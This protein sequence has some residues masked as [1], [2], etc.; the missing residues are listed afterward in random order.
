MKSI[1]LPGL[2]LLLSLTSTTLA[3]ENQEQSIE[4]FVSEIDK[5]MPQLLHDFTVPGAAIAI[6]ENGA[7]VL[8]KGYG[9]SD[10]ENEVKVN[11]KTGFNIGSISK[12]VAAWGVMKLV[13]EGK[14]DLDAPAEKYLTRWHLPE[15]EFDSDGVT[16]RRLL[17]HTAGLSLHSVS[18]GPPYDKLPTLEDWLIGKNNGLGRVEI[19]L[20]PG[21]RYKYSGGG[22]GVLQLIIEE[23]TG[24]SFEDYM[25]SEVLDPLGMRNSSYKI[26]DKIMAASASPYDNYGEAT[27]FELF[28][29]QAGAGLHTTLED[30]TRF[31]IANLYRHKDNNK[32]NSVLPTDIIQQMMEP[33]LATQGR[34]RRGLGYL[35][36]HMG[37]SWVFSGHGGSNT[38]WQANFTVDPASNDG[39]VGFTNGGAGYAICNMLSCEWTTWKTGES[40]GNW[41]QAKPSIANK[42]KQIIDSKGIDDL[43]A[44]YTELKENQFE[45]YDFS[46]GQLNQFGYYYLAKDDIEKAIAIFKINVDAF[47]NAFNVYDSYGEALLKQGA[48]EEAIE[49]YRKSIKLNPGNENAFKVLNELGISTEE[50]IKNISVAVDD[51][52]LAGY[53]G[54]YQASADETVTIRTHEG[55]LTAELKGQR[56]NLIAESTARFRV[57]QDGSAV[58]FFTAVTGQKGL[59]A[60]QRI[61]RKLPETP[62][63]VSGSKGP[64]NRSAMDSAGDFL[65]FR[66]APSWGRLTDFENVLVELGC[67]YE[68]RKSSAMADLDLSPYGVI[69]IPGAQGSDYYNDYVSNVARFDDYVAKGGTLVL[70]LNGAENTRS[71]FR[72]ASPW[73]LTAPSKTRSLHPTIRSFYLFRASV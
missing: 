66:N 13:H 24:Q 62:T 16:I 6:I 25:Q 43:D 26:D 33:V 45:Q 56:M 68:Q 72:A 63:G 55:L 52:V 22:F 70:E 21:S 9:F 40:L 18:A 41:C 64:A 51:Q 29:V 34:Y 36:T 57:L 60:R 4:Q 3:Q 58:T 73:C 7:I 65:V 2:A 17:S 10:V 11:T 69:I 19:I 54:R 20:E 37:T 48:R 1:F 12:T 46:E 39:F 50:L 67:N 30:F 23:L 35:T 15:S 42:L 44:I 27:D 53:V 28:T 47:P 59:W 38:G 32:Y 49:N 61:W 8:Q 31:A 14:I 5:K 71:C